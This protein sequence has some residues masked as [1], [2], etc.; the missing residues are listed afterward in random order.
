VFLT[1][2]LFT[3]III[4][5]ILQ[6]TAHLKICDKWRCIMW[7]VTDFSSSTP[8]RLPLG[9]AVNPCENSFKPHMLWNYNSLAT[10]LSLTVKP[11]FI[12][13]RMV[14]SERNNIRTSSVPYV[15]RTWSWIGH[16]RS[17]KV[18]LIGA[19]RNP[20]LCVVVR[21]NNSDVISETF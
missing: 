14:S 12:Q 11:M 9:S 10:F 15:K 18:I 16:S 1:P 8:V 19:G 17:F 6:T 21:Y 2:R 13:W 5:I 3:F 7:T 20:E 4:Y